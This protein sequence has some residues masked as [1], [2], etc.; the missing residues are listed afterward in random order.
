VVEV[1]G[2][3]D[4]QGYIDE[5][6][7]V[8]T[9]FVNDTLSPGGMFSI[10]GHKL[11]IAGGIPEVGVYFRTGGGPGGAGQGGRPSGGER[12]V[13]ADRD[14]PGPGRGEVAGGN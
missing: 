2:L 14:Y 1:E 10:A 8:S 11:K 3:A 5:F 13:Q 12:R 9:E 6:I 7:D 4:V